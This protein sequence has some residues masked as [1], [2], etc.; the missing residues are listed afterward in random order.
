MPVGGALGWREGAG[1]EWGAG[2]RRREAGGGGKGAGGRGRGAGGRGRG[3]GGRGRGP[4]AGGVVPELRDGA[5]AGRT[6]PVASSRDASCEL[7]RHR[8]HLARYMH[9]ICTVL[10]MHVHASYVPEGRGRPRRRGARCDA[11]RDAK[12]GRVACEGRPLGCAA[13]RSGEGEGW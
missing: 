13:P 8:P 7:P 4:G 11:R 2:G 6:A 3:A 9:G 10:R 12:P 1:Q 5:G